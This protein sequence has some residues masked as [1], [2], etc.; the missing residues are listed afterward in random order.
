MYITTLVKV[1][2]LFLPFQFIPKHMY[3]LCNYY[4]YVYTM[5]VCVFAFSIG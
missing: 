5:C 2:V 1:K 3:I 4:I